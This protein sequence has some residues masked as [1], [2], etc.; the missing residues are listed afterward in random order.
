M[1]HHL[2]ES[3][4]ITCPWPLAFELHFVCFCFKFC[5]QVHFYTIPTFRKQK[6]QR[7]EVARYALA[8]WKTLNR[9]KKSTGIQYI[10]CKMQYKNWSKVYHIKFLVFEKIAFI[11]WSNNR[12]LRAASQSNNYGLQQCFSAYRSLS[13][14][15][16]LKLYP[17]FQNSL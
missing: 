10:N 14:N 9:I 3:L 2:F 11:Y 4:Y 17:T 7:K 6:V 8:A 12:H 15:E 1:S 13:N 16:R 5:L